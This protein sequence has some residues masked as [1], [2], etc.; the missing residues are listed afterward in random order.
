MD[1]HIGFGTTLAHPWVRIG[2]GV[3]IGNRCTLGMCHI[4]D[5]ATIGSNVDL[6]SGRRHHGFA[7][8]TQSVQTQGGQLATIR[9]GRN[10]WLGN[11]CVVMDDI[12][13]GAVVGAGAVVVQPVPAGAVVV[14]NPG[15]VKRVRA[16]A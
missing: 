2:R 11:S 3:Y 14:G 1:V 6:L 7:D 9:V 12:G 8:P 4:G 10:T 15:V 13:E 16:V 5:H